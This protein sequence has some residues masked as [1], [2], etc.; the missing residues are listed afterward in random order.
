MK[1]EHR[2]PQSRVPCPQELDGRCCELDARSSELGSVDVFA[3]QTACRFCTL[4][5][6]MTSC[7]LSRSHH[8]TV[9]REVIARV[10]A[11]AS[12]CLRPHPYPSPPADTRLPSPSLSPADESTPLRAGTQR[13]TRHV[14][15]RQ[16]VPA[17]LYSSRKP[18]RP[19][20]AKLHVSPGGAPEARQGRGCND[21]RR[22]EPAPP[23]NRHADETTSAVAE[24]S[25]DRPALGRR[26][27]PWHTFTQLP[28]GGLSDGI[29]HRRSA[30]HS[31]PHIATSR[32]EPRMAIASVTPR[33]NSEPGAR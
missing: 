30:R 22:V 5:S 3:G 1:H 21:P 23:H 25:T 15:H 32:H 11:Q 6:T 29:C 7:S 20:V 8:N 10:D 27:T 17:G 12:L 14:C 16:F 4:L 26:T 24:P 18:Q 2:C 31:P 13:S 9:L 28:C 19:A 33:T